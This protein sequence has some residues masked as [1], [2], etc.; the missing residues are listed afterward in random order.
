MFRSKVFSVLRSINRNSYDIG[1]T[2]LLRNTLF[3]TNVLHGN[4][5]DTSNVILNEN[6]ANT[7]QQAQTLDETIQESKTSTENAEVSTEAS[8]GSNTSSFSTEPELDKLYKKLEIEVRGNDPA[9]LRSYG[10]FA[11]M[12][13]GHLDITVGRHVAIRKPIFE[14][15]TLLKSIH[16]HKKH[17]VQYETRTYYRYVDLFN[18]TGSTA[19]TYLEYIE[20][21][22]PEGVAMKITKVELQT[23]PKTVEQA[24]SLQQ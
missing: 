9:V 5:S 12:V 24:K 14:R 7:S 17:R 11:V 8:V 2:K 19:D 21:N 6:L 16:V 22:L 13:A 23:L 3:S 15:L 20:R 10:E 18:L 4:S 1:H